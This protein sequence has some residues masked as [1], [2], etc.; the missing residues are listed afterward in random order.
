MQTFIALAQHFKAA[1][2]FSL[3]LNPFLVWSDN[4]EACFHEGTV[5]LWWLAHFWGDNI[6]AGAADRTNKY[7]IKAA[8]VAESERPGGPAPKRSSTEL[9]SPAPLVL[10]LLSCADTA[11]EHL[12]PHP[13]EAQH[14]NTDFYVL[15]KTSLVQMHLVS[16]TLE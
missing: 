2:P 7:V 8:F 6:S 5:H 15:A 16:V 10:P 4:M 13:S 14:K 3:D 11:T 9:N 12:L 1:E